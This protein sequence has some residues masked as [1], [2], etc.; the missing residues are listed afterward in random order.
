VKN[1]KEKLEEYEG[2]NKKKVK[3]LVKK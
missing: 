1:I 2:K 3:K